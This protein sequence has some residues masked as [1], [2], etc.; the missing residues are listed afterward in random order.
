MTNYFI[1]TVEARGRI[2]IDGSEIR[3]FEDVDSFK[4]KLQP[5]KAHNPE[6][7]TVSLINSF[8]NSS[9]EVCYFYLDA[10]P[11]LTAPSSAPACSHDHTPGGVPGCSDI[12]LECH[13]SGAYGV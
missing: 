9:H 10:Y 5:L 12:P 7:I 6:A 4:K 13:P 11:R 3:P 1:Q 8:A 2:A